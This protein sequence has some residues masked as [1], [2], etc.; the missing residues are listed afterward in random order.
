MVNFLLFFSW[1][2]WEEKFYLNYNIFFYYIPKLDFN[3]LYVFLLVLGLVEKPLFFLL[4]SFYQTQNSL[5]FKCFI[6]SSSVIEIFGPKARYFWARYCSNTRKMFVAHMVRSIPLAK[7]LTSMHCFWKI[8]HIYRYF[9]K[10]W[11]TYLL[12]QVNDSWEYFIQ[13]FFFIFYN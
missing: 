1:W 3:F 10:V 13:A 2:N 12:A 6:S 7:F 4:F 9:R 11:A 8:W 5:L